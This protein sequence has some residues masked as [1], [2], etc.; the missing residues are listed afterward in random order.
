[1]TDE[2]KVLQSS[3]EESVSIDLKDEG[4]HLLLLE[5]LRVGLELLAV[6]AEFLIGTYS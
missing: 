5:H 1:L 4:K 2:Q 3:I 6:Y